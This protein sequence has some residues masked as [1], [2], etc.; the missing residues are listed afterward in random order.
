[1]SSY[2]YVIAASEQGP[3]KVGISKDPHRRLRQLQTGQA[4]P[5]RLFHTEAIEEKQ[6][7]LMEKAVHAD[8]RHKKLKGEW[9]AMSVE[10]AILEVRHAMIRHA[11]EVE[12]KA[13]FK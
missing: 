2:I 7:L 11:D 10:D 6:A 1:M 3:V 5:L 12:R 13:S 8:N 9:F 4:E